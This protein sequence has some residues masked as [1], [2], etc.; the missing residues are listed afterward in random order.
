M[1]RPRKKPKLSSPALI[2]SKIGGAISSTKA[3]PEKPTSIEE[4]PQKGK[5][6]QL[7]QGAHVPGI[8]IA[9]IDNGK[10]YSSVLG[11]SD[12]E[13]KEAVAPD[14]VFWA[15]SLSKPVFA[16]LIIKMI[17]NKELSK[18]FLDRPL[19]WDET[20]LGP[21]GDKKPLTPRMILSHRTGLP[22]GQTGPLPLDFKFK[23]DEG[24]RYSGEGFKYLQRC[25]TQ[26]QS[27]Q[28]LAQK[29]LFGPLGMN[30]SSF[31]YPGK[32]D[33]ATTHDETMIPNPSPKGYGNDDHAA[34]S[35]HTTA[36]DY[37]LFLIDFLKNKNN[38][39]YL[40]LT[41]PQVP[42]MEKDVDAKDKKVAP[43]TLKPINWGLG[44][45][46]QTNDKGEP[47]T[48]FHWGEGPGE[49]NFFAI[50]L[51]GPSSAFVYF[52]NSNNG[53]SI[54]EELASLT[55]EKDISSII[56]F[57]YEKEGYEK[58]STQEWKKYFES[59][60]AGTDAEKKGHF[61]KAI[62]LYQQA[63]DI[64][65]NN[66]LNHRIK[67]IEAKMR[68]QKPSSVSEQKLKELEGTYGPIKILM[69]DSKLQIDMG[70]LQDITTVDENTFLDENMKVILTFTR[71]Q[72]GSVTSLECHFPWGEKEAYSH[73]PPPP[74]L[75]HT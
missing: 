58:S 25:I 71:D 33:H 21:Q 28:E 62:A 24:F 56:K 23:P 61:S 26:K 41:K 30:H 48:A 70:Q 10:I 54:P 9:M 46:L 52:A 40:D 38:K 11:V 74:Q 17:E 32:V 43:K 1:A 50:H 39:T 34:A 15:C 36:Y 31:L 37:S 8:S 73:S 6:H 18:D 22:N 49:R 59:L 19:P 68:P 2:E 29:N 51:E 16:Y 47:I 5:I 65:P 64:K 69:K 3:T 72:T 75:K 63:F 60:L 13:S 27:L 67:W 4:I 12:I 35:L 20:Y 45:G 14:T 57:L 66:K 42:D 53:L 44:F 55:T 7:M